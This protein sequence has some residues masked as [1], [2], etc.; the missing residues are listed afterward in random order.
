MKIEV[1]VHDSTK[2][3]RIAERL[4]D[5]FFTDQLGIVTQPMC[6]FSD[7]RN[8]RFARRHPITGYVRERPRRDQCTWGRL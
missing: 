7:H 1:I 5:E 6:T 3:D 2:A 8:S 4:M